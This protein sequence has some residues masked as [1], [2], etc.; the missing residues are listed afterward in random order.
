MQP[1]HDLHR[2]RMARNVWV[3][4]MLLAFVLLIFGLTVVKVT[5]GDVAGAIL[6]ERVE[7]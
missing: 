3:G 2:R 4:G 5:E 7:Q 1:D 6:N